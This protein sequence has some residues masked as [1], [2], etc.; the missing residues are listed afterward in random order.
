MFS[1]ACEYALR[2]MVYIESDGTDLKKRSL[3]ETVQTTHSPVAFA[4]ERVQH[5]QPNGHIVSYTG[6]M[7]SFQW[8]SGTKANLHAIITATAGDEF[9]NR[10]VPDLKTGTSQ[11]PC[12]PSCPSHA[13]KEMIIRELLQCDIRSVAE[14]ARNHSIKIKGKKLMM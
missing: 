14:D 1:S 8:V 7:G 6:A 5:L 3:Q 2:A 13:L 9:Y 10:Y 11:N 4:P 12:P